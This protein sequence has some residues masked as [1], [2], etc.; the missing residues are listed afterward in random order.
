MPQLIPREQEALLAQYANQF[1]A[2]LVVGPRQSGKTTLVRSAF[3]QKPYASL[4]DPD[5]RLLASADPRAFLARFPEG[6]ILDE[7][8]RVPGLLNYLQGIL[9]EAEKDGLFILT[10]SNN[11]LLQEN[12]SQS[13]AG[14]VGILDLLP[15][16]YRE[17]HAAGMRPG[18]DALIFHGSYPE[19]HGRGRPPGAWYS[20]YVRTYVERDVRQVK[21]IADTLLFTRFLRLCAGRCGQLLNVAALS[22]DCGIDVKTVNAWLSVLESTYIIK[23][24]QPYHAN[25]NKRIVKSPKLYFVDTGLAC[26][27][28]GI[29]RVEE[30][31]LSHFRGALVENLIIIEVLK[32][33]LNADAEQALYFWRDNKGVEVDL[34][35]DRGRDHLPVEIKS[36]Q[37][38]TD[39][40]AAG[41]K[42]FMAWS[43]MGS[44]AVLYDG[45]MEFTTST[46]VRV[47]NWRTYL[48]EGP[49]AA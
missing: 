31:R 11:I 35:V 14:R 47:L 41:L 4:E 37:T 7:V 44:G 30:L 28:L 5:E 40:L 29:R 36:A 8:Q 19:V 3:P 39:D 34:I 12:V 43:A 16:S 20:A 48:L 42:R 38:W 33:G 17:L 24:L 49:A 45:G 22:N 32:N 15:M 6:A 1:R 13:L 25:Y 18:L 21:N 46:G 27:L 23:L 26:A 10:G 9:D 2:V